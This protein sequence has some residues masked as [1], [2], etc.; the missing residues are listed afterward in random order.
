[1]GNVLKRNKVKHYDAYANIRASQFIA[2]QNIIKPKPF[3]N[4]Q[5]VKLAQNTSV[6]K[7]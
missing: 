1:M 3:S 5:K 4:L 6:V 7:V 2:Q